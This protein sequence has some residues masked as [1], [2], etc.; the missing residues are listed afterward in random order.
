MSASITD[1]NSNGQTYTVPIEP[2][3]YYLVILHLYTCK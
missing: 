2:N 1:K 3:R